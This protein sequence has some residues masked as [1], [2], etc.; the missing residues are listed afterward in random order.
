MRL[1]V[2]DVGD[3]AEVARARGRDPA[4]VASIGRRE[5]GACTSSA[6]TSGRAARRGRDLELAS[7]EAARRC[8]V[9]VRVN[10][11]VRDHARA[12]SIRLAR[13]SGRHRARVAR[14]RRPRRSRPPTRAVASSSAASARDAAPARPWPS[15]AAIARAPSPP[16]A[17][18][19]VSTER[20]SRGRPL[21]HWPQPGSSPG[22]GHDRPRRSC[23]G[24]TRSPPRAARDRPPAPG[25][26]VAAGCGRASGCPSRRRRPA[27][28]AIRRRAPAGPSG[29]G[30]R[31]R[32]WRER[33]GI[34]PTSDA[35]R[36]RQ[37]DLKS[38]GTTRSHAFPRPPISEPPRGPRPPRSRRRALRQAPTCHGGARRRRARRTPS[39]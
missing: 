5:A 23:Q 12:A 4:Q 16:P 35:I 22:A 32:G 14:R 7:V 26:A 18:A 15:H 37:K 20:R 29:H 38:P 31:R 19:R 11:Q 17:R 21:S 36:A 25:A 3:D 39:P 13:A 34:E 27:A 28:C 10:C 6:G 9:H 1:A 8:G 30:R 2:V 33:V 24:R